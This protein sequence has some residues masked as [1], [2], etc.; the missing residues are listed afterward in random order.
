MILSISLGR[1]H[2]IALIPGMAMTGRRA[3]LLR[4]FTAALT[5]APDAQPAPRTQAAS[6]A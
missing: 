6:A 5:Q 4:E 3:D 1:N 2:S